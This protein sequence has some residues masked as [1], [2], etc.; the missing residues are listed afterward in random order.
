MS[1]TRPP[2]RQISRRQPA[3]KNAA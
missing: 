3:G 2:N 1:L